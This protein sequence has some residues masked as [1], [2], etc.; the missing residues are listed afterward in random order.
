MYHRVAELEPDIWRLA[1]SPGHFEEQLQLLSRK[2][3]VMPL[4]ELTEDLV[5]NKLRR[6]SVALSFDDG[7]VDNFLF[8]KPLLEKYKLPATFFACS[9]NAGQQSEFWWD[10]LERIIL[11]TPQLPSSFSIPLENA[12]VTAE[13]G[14]EKEL[15]EGLKLQHRQW[16]A[17]VQPPP[18]SRA[19]LFLQLWEALKPLPHPRQQEHLAQIKAWA[20]VTYICPR[21]LSHS[22]NTEQLLALGSNKLFSFGAHTV[23][24]PDLAAHPKAMQQR[25]IVEN[26][27]FLEELGQKCV[28]VL[29][30]P[31]G[32]YSPDTMAVAAEMGF[33][34]AFT[35]DSRPVKPNSEPY[36]LGRFLVENWNGEELNH[37]M[38]QWLMA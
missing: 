20:G 27:Q 28:R 8:A 22:M 3:R 11:H 21:P 35:T 33:T 17:Y 31:Y 24:H 25:E 6:K 29:A 10:E 9:G 34:A 30:Y 14:E 32:S 16:K 7:Y 19:A 2:W 38:R 23:S 15:T 18:S 36:R 12:R 13:L 5:S 37:H 26:K 4:P 1:V